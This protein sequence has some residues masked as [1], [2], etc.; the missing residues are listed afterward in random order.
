LRTGIADCL[1]MREADLRVI[2][3]DV[4]GGFGQKMS[5]VPEYVLLVWAAP[6][7]EPSDCLDRGSPR[8]SHRR[9]SQP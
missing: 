4:G 2:A 1:G 7:A 6:P 3:P 8:E 9:L 5:L